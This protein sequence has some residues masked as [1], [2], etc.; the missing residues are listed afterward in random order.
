MRVLLTYL[1]LILAL[2]MLST[3]GAVVAQDAPDFGA[4]QSLA[5]SV[6]TDLQEDRLSDEAFE[7]L[8]AK[9]VEW[10]G[11]LLAAQDINEVQIEALTA[12]I[13]ALGAAPAEG[14]TEPED[15]AARRAA[16][17]QQL[18]TAREPR[19]QAEE[20]YARANTL[21]GRIDATLR[22]RQADEIFR[23]QRT[24]LDP[25]LWSQAIASLG[26]A[27][28]DLRGELSRNIAARIERGTLWDGLPV[29]VLLLISAI[30]LISRGPRW[31]E[32]LIRRIEARSGEQA[33]IVYGFLVS[34]GAIAAPVLG[35]SL[36]NA[37]LISTELLGPTGRSLALGINVA[38]FAYAIARWLG[39][40]LFPV[41]GGESS[42][43]ALSDPAR[44]EGRF[45]AQM[46][47]LGTG[48]LL[49]VEVL[50]E[51]DI[52]SSE[53]ASVISLPLF[54]VLGLTL[55][56]LGRLLTHVGSGKN[57]AAGPNFP[58]TVVHLLGRGLQAVA[59]LGPLAAAIG[60]YQ[61]AQSLMLP[62]AST[63][64]MLGLLSILHVFIRAA[65]GLARGLSSKQAAQALTPVLISF[66]FWI[67]AIPILALIWGAR[68]TDIGELWA[69]FQ[70]GVRVGDTTISPGAFLTFA[71]VFALGFL[72]TR[73]VQG[74]LKSSVLP[75]TSMDKGGQNA[76]I[77]GLGYVGVTLAAIAGI[78]SAGIDLS[79]LAIIVGA[80]GVGIGFGLQ[81]IVNNFV[82]GIILLIER[83]ISEG[84]W[85]Q[86]NGQMGIVKA[87][88]VRSTRIE[89]FDRTD[90]IVPNGDLISGTVTNWTRGN[91]IGRVIVPV[92]VAYGTDTKK[93]ET[94]LKEIAE[95]H[96]MVVSVPPPNV[97][98]MRFGAD[99][100]DFEIRAILKDV[101][102]LL[103][104]HSD[105]NHEIAR[106]F[107]EEGI[108]IPFAQR[109]IW[110]RNPEA[111][112]QAAV[113]PSE[114][115][116]PTG[117]IDP[118]LTDPEGSEPE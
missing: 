40:R 85:V 84:D 93:V 7:N 46:L 27:V 71:V 86:V 83:P 48:L 91:S 45:L 33:R 112:R 106:R 76:V 11:T 53:V 67:C 78:T 17:N 79:N 107:A 5:N 37:A 108:E 70:T 100:L 117:P 26:S 94:I 51:G 68:T 105:M 116:P 63:I 115:R 41:A 54:V 98:F 104:V 36:I 52:F 87:I 13:D 77:S 56:R 18:A 34:L 43:L 14:T 9:L 57:E 113:A 4:F 118:S 75:R 31:I 111:L 3:G 99:S 16:L 80:L 22:D 101:N 110:L 39:G 73:L 102:F 49:L 23:L 61:M 82:S 89:T 35:I 44:T 42:P 60:Y 109:D 59:I 12:Q 95:A 38:I 24:P 58:A 20:S 64:S 69:R 15:I 55:F 96:P 28:S 10:R 47:G 74:T 8:R 90:V 97:F 1:R 66:V 103:S 88:S 114:P 32:H 2:G 21:I 81:N 92:G 72:L 50:G 65:F 25:A 6:E 30:I 19:L 29:V 62:T